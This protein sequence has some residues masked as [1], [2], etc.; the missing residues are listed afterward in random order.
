MIFNT[1]HYE[2]TPGINYEYVS[3]PASDSSKP[4]FLFLHGFPSSFY[5][6]RNQLKH[7]SEQ[8]YGCL[9][10]NL[11]GYGKTY[12]PLSPDEY[13]GKSMVDH[14]VALLDHLKL[15]RVIVVGHDWGVRPATRFVL[16]HPERTLGVVLVSAGYHRP[17]QLDHEKMLQMS[18]QALGYENTGY[19]KFF[20]A[21]DAA[22]LI[23]KNIDAFIDLAFPKDPKL[24]ATDFA[25][26]GKLREWVT[27]GKRTERAPFLTEDDC[28]VLR[29]NA[30]DGMQPKLNWYKSALSN[31]DWEDEK[32]LDPQIK[33]PL[34]FI[35][36]TKDYICIPKLFAE[37]GKFVPELESVELD[38]SHW[39]MEEKPD[40]VNRTIEAWVK[41]LN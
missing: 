29:R 14:L 10:P 35:G 20:A 31:I 22:E 26:L 16:Y 25:P 13:R 4:T 23:E 30:E 36:G 24:W 6:W 3:L 9:A 41:K 33:R 7:F 2:V 8:G 38:S 40:E 1:Q 21:D 28:R 19:W 39:I 12:S 18:K 11:L 27:E 17:S 5:C 34:L 32:D 15:D 37:Q